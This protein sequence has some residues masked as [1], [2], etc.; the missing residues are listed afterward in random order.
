VAIRTQAQPPN[1][2]DPCP[3]AAIKGQLVEDSTWGLALR[4]TDNATHGVVW[5][6]G[7]SARRDAGTVVLLNPSG[8]SVA[9]EGD[10]VRMAG[11]VGDDGV[12]HPCD[13]LEIVIG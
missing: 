1:P 11:T 2:D 6:Y 9:K 7:Y 13:P 12:A 8:T 3:A 5:G 4:S 10:S